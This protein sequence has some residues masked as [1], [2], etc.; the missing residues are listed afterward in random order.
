MDPRREVVSQASA[1]G[2]R[3]HGYEQPMQAM[4]T[5]HDGAHDGVA[6]RPDKGGGVEADNPN[7]NATSREP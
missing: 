4:S 3:A 1:A 6:D 7:P 2:E 5:S